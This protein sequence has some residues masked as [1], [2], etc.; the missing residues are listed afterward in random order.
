[1][2]KEIGAAILSRV[3]S[4]LLEKNMTRAELERKA[5]LGN[6]TLRNWSNSMPSIDKVQRVARILNVTLDYLYHGADNDE[7]RLLARDIKE[8][9]VNTQNIIKNIIKS[10]KNN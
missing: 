5:D 6:G 3:D 8:L 2:K 4:L 7:I 9:D 1:M 10:N